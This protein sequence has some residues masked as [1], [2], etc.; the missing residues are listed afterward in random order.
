MS[1]H[2]GIPVDHTC[3]WPSLFRQLTTTLLQ[4]KLLTV[5]QEKQV[6]MVTSL[7][8]QGEI[9]VL[10][11]FSSCN[12]PNFVHICNHRLGEELL[13]HDILYVYF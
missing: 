2:R 5:T 7:Q 8:Y 4:Q 6:A 12:D 9:I 10:L 3:M 13:S 1:L 11:S